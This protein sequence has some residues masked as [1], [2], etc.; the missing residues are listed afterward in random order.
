MPLI[1][2]G[3]HHREMRV[4]WINGVRFKSRFITIF[5][6]NN[7][8]SRARSFMS[9]ALITAKIRE[10]I[11]TA[12]RLANITDINY[13]KRF[14]RI[15]FY[16]IYVFRL[17]TNFRSIF[18]KTCNSILKMLPFLVNTSALRPDIRVGYKTEAIKQNISDKITFAFRMTTTF[19]RKQSRNVVY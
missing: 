12:N 1:N 9:H 13:A 17:N 3:M 11:Q 15:S 7:A 14:S 19:S 6:A 2:S 5:V 16:V 10:K 4:Q 8:V 18:K